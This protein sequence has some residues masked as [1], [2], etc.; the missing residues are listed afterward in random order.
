MALAGNNRRKNVEGMLAHVREGIKAQGVHGGGKETGEPTMLTDYDLR[1]I[2]GVGLSK[3]EDSRS[4]S[5]P[6]IP[7]YNPPQSATPRR[8]RRPDPEPRLQEYFVDQPAAPSLDNDPP[9]I[10][11]SIFRDE[12]ASARPRVPRQ[13][14]DPFEIASAERRGAMVSRENTPGRQV[15]QWEPYPAP[16]SRSDTRIREE[17]VWIG[18]MINDGQ[19]VILREEEL[20]PLTVKELEKMGYSYLIMSREQEYPSV[21]SRSQYSAYQPAITPLQPA[22]N[23]ALGNFASQEYEY[24]SD[25]GSRTLGRKALDW[26]SSDKSRGKKKRSWKVKAL[27]AAASVGVLY[28]GPYVAGRSVVCEGDDFGSK[29]ACAFGSSL[30]IGARLIPVAG[31]IHSTLASG[32]DSVYDLFGLSAAETDVETEATEKEPNR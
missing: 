6:P 22:Q 13:T 9:D 31:G 28:V 10:F 32:M 30:D 25:N 19:E 11:D 7:T 20:H 5:L 1:I 23:P 24:H 12:A 27:A 8:E 4:T 2:N 26:L 17:I 3:S 18:N 29:T 15:A 21:V 16:G 14:V